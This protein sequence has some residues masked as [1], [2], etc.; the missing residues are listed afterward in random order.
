MKAWFSEVWRK[1]WFP[2]NYWKLMC[3]KTQILS[4]AL[5]RT[6]VVQIKDQME[7]CKLA[8]KLMKSLNLCFNWLWI[9]KIETWRSPFRKEEKINDNLVPFSYL[10]QL[11]DY[12]GIIR[13]WAECWLMLLVRNLCISRIILLITNT[14]VHIPWAPVSLVGKYFFFTRASPW[15]WNEDK[16]KSHSF[17]RT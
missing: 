8:K 4:S 1:C 5:I 2:F 17:V 9:N 13:V 12:S 15:S 10:F 11:L 16:E 6:F 7:W 3:P 14:C